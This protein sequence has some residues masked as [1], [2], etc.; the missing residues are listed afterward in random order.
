M[1]DLVR[2]ERDPDAPVATITL[3]R[4]GKRNALSSALIGELKAAYDEV[5]DVDDVTCVVLTGA[6]PAFCAGMDLEELG[7]G[8]SNLGLD[9]F[10][11]LWDTS[12]PVIA[13]VN[14]VAAT[15][16]LELAL[17]CDMIVASEN[18]RFVDTHVR[19]GV[20]PGAGMSVLWPA[21]LGIRKATE[22]SLAGRPLS[23]ADAE[24]YGLVNEVVPHDDLMPAALGLAREIAANDA[25]MVKQM[26]RLFK[27]HAR[28]PVSEALA[29]ESA[30]FAEF[31]SADLDPAEVEARRAAVIARG[32]SQR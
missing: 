22:L 6:D 18:A 16:G 19:V 4:P 9:F 30:N 2:V 7:A 12:T 13:A 23:A 10:R 27:D 25:A 31:R 24:R 8:G 21:I 26:N 15:G 3:N 17:A 11:R 5:L 29:H 20:V 28:L 32:R 14:G 1:G